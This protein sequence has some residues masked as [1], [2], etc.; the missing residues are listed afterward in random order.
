[1]ALEAKGPAI[2]C[3]S[4][5]L[6]SFSISLLWMSFPPVIHFGWLSAVAYTAALG[7]ALWILPSLLG[8]KKKT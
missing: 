6:I 1:L 2:L 5:I 3:T 4:L 7:S 8:I